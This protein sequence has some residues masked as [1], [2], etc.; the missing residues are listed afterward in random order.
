MRLKKLEVINTIDNTL[1]REIIFNKNG[2]SLFVDDTNKGSG[3][4]IGKSTAAKV[5]D[6]CL[7]A[8]STSDIY[9]EDDTGENEVVKN[10]IIRNKVRAK[11]YTEIDGMEYIFGR[12]LFPRGK[13][14][15]N[16]EICKS[17][18]KFR[19]DL[20]SIIFDNNNSKP[21]FRQ[22]ISK[23]I[24]LDDINENNLL[25]YIPSTSNLTYHLVYSF[26]LK[27][28]TENYDSYDALETNKSLQKEINVILK[29]NAVS[30]PEELET[31]V[32]LLNSSLEDLKETY[33][34]LS[35]FDDFENKRKH[36]NELTH[37]INLLEE[38]IDYLTLRKNILDDKINK[39]NAKIS[40]IDHSS[41][42][43][44]YDETVS[45]NLENTLKSFK[46]L[47][48]FHNGM[49]NKRI[50]ILDKNQIEI[51]NRIC[52]L[53][54]KL[55]SL[56]EEFEQNYTTFDFEFANKFEEH[57]DTYNQTKENYIVAKDD[58]QYVLKL[59]KEIND[60]LK[61]ANNSNTHKESLKDIEMNFN[62]YFSLL[63][64]DILG[65]KFALCIT[66]DK[67]KF[68]LSITGLNGKLGTGTKKAMI[69]CF[70]LALIEYAIDKKIKMPYFEIHD[71]MENI[72][73][74]E[75]ENI[76]KKSRTLDSQYIFPILR[77]RIKDLGVSD[78]EIVLKLSKEEKFFLI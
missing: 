44:L 28:N 9:K 55:K 42:K 22:L 36:I 53:D 15:I 29:K 45:I 71:K 43:K 74:S 30:S 24:R 52:E 75:L 63:T 18:D 64:N 46:E 12:D 10:F 68:P 61:I 49:I 41:L 51:Q 76:I 73:L 7:G 56:K 1:I 32:M 3:S 19:D 60:N 11:L 47:E 39:E 33:K 57:F 77:D 5:I 59:N 65:E 67:E 31:K 21:T 13:C 40:N 25:K 78:S 37:K 70:D 2:L 72:P 20:N 34:N 14:F 6:L 35:V 48:D 50:D 66:D 54:I 62:N 16:E 27:L 23:F 26:L 38:E 69:S 8:K 17:S 58:Y 4:N